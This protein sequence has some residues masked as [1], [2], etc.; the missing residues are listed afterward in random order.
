M[1]A[2]FLRQLFSSVVEKVGN[3]NESTFIRQ[4]ASARRT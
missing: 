1:G 4:A 3:N 2:N